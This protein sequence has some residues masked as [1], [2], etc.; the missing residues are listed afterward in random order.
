MTNAFL[1]TALKLLVGDEEGLL[2]VILVVLGCPK[3]R[4]PGDCMIDTADAPSILNMLEDTSSSHLLEVGFS[5]WYSHR[6][7]AKIAY[8][9][10]HFILFYLLHTSIFRFLM[11]AQ[12]NNF[13]LEIFFRSF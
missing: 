9:W 4:A 10:S 12:G 11:H 7:T 6:G 8:I 2:R 5:S 1:Q 3:E 13:T